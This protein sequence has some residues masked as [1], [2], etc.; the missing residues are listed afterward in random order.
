MEKPQEKSSVI[1][2]DNHM[3]MGIPTAM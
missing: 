3:Y 2:D 1:V